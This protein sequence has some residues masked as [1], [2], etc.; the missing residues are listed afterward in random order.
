MTSFAEEFI[1]YY[2]AKESYTKL[3]HQSA[4][5]YPTKDASTNGHSSGK[6]KKAT[7]KEHDF[8]LL[9]LSEP[10]VDIAALMAEMQMAQEETREKPSKENSKGK[11]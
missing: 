1:A 9:E 5:A 10:R 8:F 6:V 2:K 11:K 3:L 4:K 7:R